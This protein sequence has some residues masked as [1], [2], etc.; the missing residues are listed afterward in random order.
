V[1]EEIRGE[2]GRRLG[3]MGEEIRGEWGEEMEEM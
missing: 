2:W 3:G 1:G